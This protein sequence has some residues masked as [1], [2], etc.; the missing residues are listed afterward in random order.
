MI[1]QTRFAPFSLLSFFL[2]LSSV[3]FSTLAFAQVETGWMVNPDHPPAKTRFVVTGQVNPTDKTVEG[4]LEVALE[5]DWKTYWRSPGEGGI[6]PSISWQG[7]S[8]LESVDWHW[9][10]PQQFNLLGINTL[11]Y[12]GDTL[13]PMTLHVEDFYKPVSLDAKLTLSSCTTICVL[14]DYPFSLDFIPSELVV[15]EQ[16]MYQHA[17]AISQVPKAS[18][19][20]SEQSAVWDSSTNQLQVTLIKP[21]GWDVPELI[22]DSRVEAI[23]DYSYA[24]NHLTV[25]GE[26]LVAV[27]DVSTWLGDINLSE[28]SVDVTIKDTDFIAEQAAQVTKGLVSAPIPSFSVV[29]MIGFALLGGLILNVMP[30][31][32]PVLGMKL[33]GVISAQGIERRKVRLQFLASSAGILTSFWLLAAFLLILKFSGSAIGWGIQF[34]SPWFI[35]FMVAV[36]ALFGANMLGLFEIRLSSNTNTWLASK[37]DDSYAGHYLQGMFATLLATPCSAPFLGTA[38]AFALAASTVDMLVIFTALALGMALPWI[39]VALFP[40]LASYLP[41]PGAWMNKVKLLFGVMMLLTSVW[42]LYLLANHLP[43]FW[44]IVLAVTALV[45]VLMRIK[46]VYSD[47]AFVISGGAS[48]LLLAGGLVIGSMTADHWSTPLPEDLPWVRLSNEAVTESVANG[49]T[50]F[51]NVTADWCVTCKANKIGVILQ[52]PVY[53]ALQHPN[54]TPIQ[55]DWTHPDGLVTDYLRANG[56]FGV[57]F[58]IVYGPNAPQGIPLPVILTD[59][60]VTQALKQASGEAG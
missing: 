35:G 22:V 42:L 13:I 15:S 21:L 14:T 57:P 51:V 16:A 8:N 59:E 53:S 33:S 44:V 23:S 36:T 2:M 41:K 52:D 58:N 27:F 47:K 17:Q 45:V 9:P 32:L 7:S 19:L 50:V 56:R 37:G 3:L 46:K 1:K 5:G 29:E 11:G 12:K 48:L 30:C 18:P 39:V 38:V 31:V 10:Y 55:G 4:F 6:A 26:K 20:I 43:V 34:Q 40:G 28:Q 25:E 54:V 49:N 60:S 24:L